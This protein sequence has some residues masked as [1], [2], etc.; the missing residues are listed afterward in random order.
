ML[1]VGLPAREKIIKADDLVALIDE[2]VAEMGTKESGS[3]SNENT[4][5]IHLIKKLRWEKANPCQKNG[6][7][8][9]THDT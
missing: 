4:H 7:N 8:L 6:L 9:T 5:G 2:S 3:A 1:D